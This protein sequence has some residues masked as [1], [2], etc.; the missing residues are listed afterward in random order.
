MK[1]AKKWGEKK[2]EREDIKRGRGG[3]EGW[4]ELGKFSAKNFYSNREKRFFL[5]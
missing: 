2:K 3:G 4:G 1:M 5:Q